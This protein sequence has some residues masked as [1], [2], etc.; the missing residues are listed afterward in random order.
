MVRHLTLGTWGPSALLLYKD[1]VKRMVDRKAGY[2]ISQRLS[3]VIRR[4]NTASLL[5]TLPHDSDDDSYF[6]ALW[7]VLKCFEKADFYLGLRL[8]NVAMLPI[9]TDRQSLNKS[10]F[11]W[12]VITLLF[13]S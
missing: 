8:C 6:D 13:E 4:G 11:Q 2:Y 5:D 7:C 10:L 3:I 1:I 12:C 9:L